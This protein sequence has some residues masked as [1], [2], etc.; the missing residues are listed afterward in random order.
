MPHDLALIRRICAL[1]EREYDPALYEYVIEKVIPGTRMHPDVAIKGKASGKIQCVVEIGYTRPEKLTAYRRELK[2][3]DVR[4]YDKQGVL[5]ADVTEKTVKVTV[6]IVPPGAMAIYDVLWEEIGCWNEDC[7]AAIRKELDINCC[8][9]SG[10]LFCA[11]CED[12]IAK[13]QFRH[14][15]TMIV[16]DNFKVFLPS[17]CYKCGSKFFADEEN[18][19]AYNLI[20]TIRHR[21]PREFA[22]EYGARTLMAWDE[23]KRAVEQEFGLELDYAD[24]ILL[25]EED[26]SDQLDRI[27]LTAVSEARS[28]TS[29]APESAS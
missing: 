10:A 18:I 27:R 2:I 13:M 4:W 23:T 16:M 5:H 3:P 17:C 7:L 14:V 1:L 25:R 12:S 28:V 21:S 11:E 24:G 8:L 22:R 26:Y 19:D 20:Q 6:E 15:S 29:E 9:D